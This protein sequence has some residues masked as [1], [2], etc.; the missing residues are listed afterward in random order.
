MRESQTTGLE[1][2][3][4]LLAR[5][6]LSID[7]M[8]PGRT[9]FLSHVGAVHKLV[10]GPWI[11]HR[12]LLYAL[13]LQNLSPDQRTSL[14]RAVL[15]DHGRAFGV[16]R[17]VLTAHDSGLPLG[18][19]SLLLVPR[20]RGPT[21][22]Y[23]WALGSG[24]TGA[25]C[26]WM[27]LRAQP[28]WSLDDPHKPLTARAIE[29]L[30]ALEAR[31]VI[32]VATAVEALQVAEQCLWSVAFTAHPRFA[33]HIAANPRPADA[34]GGIWLWPHDALTADSLRRRGPNVV[35]LV[36]APEALRRL[37]QRWAGDQQQAVELTHASCPG[38]LDRAGMLAFLN[39]C[40][41]PEVV[42]R[43]DPTW[44]Q[45]GETWLRAHGIRVEREVDA[46]QL[47]LFA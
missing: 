18:G 5:E 16:G 21:C 31:V 12:D 17:V 27:L 32:A 20:T 30:D 24:A 40:D 22:L 42:L 13:A 2:V 45:A 39:A 28:Q 38:R 33:P 23:T 34:P 3:R 4:S 11:G 1:R 36:D 35:V 6:R 8:Q 7:A 15:V 25:A 19:S 47:G 41:Q 26:E 10:V 46:T 37:A 14:A 43:G 44:A 9:C 29:T